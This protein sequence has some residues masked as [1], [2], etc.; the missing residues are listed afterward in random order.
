MAKKKA[1]ANAK[2][3]KMKNE[4]KKKNKNQKIYDIPNIREV[5]INCLHLVGHDYVVYQVPGD[6]GWGMGD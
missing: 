3:L 2:K 5:P 6:G 4:R 1:E